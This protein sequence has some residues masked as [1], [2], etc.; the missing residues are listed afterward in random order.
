MSGDQI[1]LNDHGACATVS[2]PT[3][4]MSTPMS[5]IQSGMA[6]HTRPSGRP[7]AKERSAT[8]SV[9]VERR[10]S[11]RS[12]SYASLSVSGEFENL[13]QGVPECIELTRGQPHERTLNQPAIVDR[14]HLVD[15]RV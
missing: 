6:Y 12:V 10:A 13:E 4:R 15:Q 8:D 5:R 11:S 7:D 9:R 2:R 1:T 3:T 14:A